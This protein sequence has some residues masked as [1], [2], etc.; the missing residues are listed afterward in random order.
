MFGRAINTHADVIAAEV[1]QRSDSAASVLG[2]SAIHH[3]WSPLAPPEPSAYVFIF[4]C[5]FAYCKVIYYIVYIG[6]M[7]CEG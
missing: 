2:L 4:V 1:E 7:V 6:A 5:L 3:N